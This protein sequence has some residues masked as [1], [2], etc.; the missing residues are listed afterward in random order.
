MFGTLAFIA[1][2][3]IVA[4]L[5]YLARNASRAQKPVHPGRHHWNRANAVS[6]GE[7]TRMLRRE[8]QR[9]LD[10]R[11]TNQHAALTA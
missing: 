11:L 4:T 7:L 1:V 8:H 5:V 9:R 6:A 10:M 3:L 2:A